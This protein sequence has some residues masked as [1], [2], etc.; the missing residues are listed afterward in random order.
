MININKISINKVEF[1]KVK[2]SLNTANKRVLFEISKEL[3]SMAEK[4]S[5]EE[6]FWKISENK[7][8]EIR[9]LQDGN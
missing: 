3:L 7:F 5:S 2:G 9:R 1:Y 6:D 8:L 4:S